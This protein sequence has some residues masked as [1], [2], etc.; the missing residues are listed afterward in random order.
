[1]EDFGVTVG[2]VITVVLVFIT[3]GGMLV[4][5]E[6]EE[7]CH[8]GWSLVG[9][10][11]CTGWTDPT[12]HITL[13]VHGPQSGFRSSDQL[14][15]THLLQRLHWIEVRPTSR[16]QRSNKILGLLGEQRWGRVM[17]DVAACK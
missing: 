15:W 12:T 14:E 16:E 6:G 4:V 11:S 8:S 13:A 9:W 5:T 17:V 3:V 2:V 1:V 7:G 10:V